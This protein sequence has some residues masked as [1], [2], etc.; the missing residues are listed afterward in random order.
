MMYKNSFR[1]LFSSANLI[2]KVML[3]FILVG[4]VVGGLTYVSALPIINV[5]AGANFFT[6]ASDIFASFFSNLNLSE[7]FVNLQDLIKDFVTIISQNI[8]SLLVYIILFIFMLVILGSFLR[9]LYSAVCGGVLY[10]LM[11]NNI[12]QPFI[13][14]FRANLIKTIKLELAR[15][16]ILLP[17]NIV[18]SVIMYYMFILT[19]LSGAMYVLAPFL[20]MLVFVVLIALKTTFFAGWMPALFVINARIYPALFKG[21]GVIH[22]RFWNIF[23]TSIALMLTVLTVNLFVGIFTLSVG[24]LVTIPASYLLFVI[25]E[26]V[27]FYFAR[28]IRFY[29]D[30][31]TIFEPKKADLTDKKKDI[32]YIM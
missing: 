4:V 20:I 27:S 5:L 14:S 13:S 3:Y 10:N 32:K 18:I 31:E 11:S 24:L 15:L 29:I 23:A 16:T 2:W 26:M 9:G 22:R 12:K 7:L 30:S 25:F 19:T 1:I 6:D 8:S 28:G 17:V 21:F